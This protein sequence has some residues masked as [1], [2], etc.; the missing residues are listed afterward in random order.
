MQ[1]GVKL[2]IQASGWGGS[3]VIDL[4]AALQEEEGRS[5]HLTFDNLFTSLKLVDVLTEK[6]I[7]CT[8]T[9]RANRLGDCPVREV[10]EMKKTARGS[11][12][13]ATDTTSGL[14]KLLFDGTTT[15]SSTLSRIRW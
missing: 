15:T 9:I 11:Y 4:V 7:A 5:Y 3:V 6:N 1:K 10:T 8:G 12:D 14:T 13:H 2:F